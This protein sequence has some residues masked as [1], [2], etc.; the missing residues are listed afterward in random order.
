[1]IFYVV[2]CPSYSWYMWGIK[3]NFVTGEASVSSYS[4]YSGKFPSVNRNHAQVIIA[5][6]GSRFEYLETFQFRA[7]NDVRMQWS[8]IHSLLPCCSLPH[9]L[10]V[11]SYIDSSHL[12]IE[13]I[14]GAA[15]S[16]S[17]NTPCDLL[18]FI[19]W[20]LLWSRWKNSEFTS[21]WLY[22]YRIFSIVT[23]RINLLN[24][25]FSGT[26]LLSRFGFA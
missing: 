13:E 21:C 20:F 14:L 23:F 8:D 25:L 22:M 12:M 19:C 18:I 24:A 15:V 4:P 2:V 26:I 16:W 10:L 1:M 7:K 9:I 3:N 6:S 5:S 11:L 17:G